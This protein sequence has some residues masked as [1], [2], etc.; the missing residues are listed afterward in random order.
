MT[1]EKQTIGRAK[2]VLVFGQGDRQKAVISAIVVRR[3][4]Q[5]NSDG[6]LRFAGNVKFSSSVSDHVKET[7]LPIVDN[8]INGL[9]LSP[10]NFEI[11]AVNLGVAS[12]LDVGMNISGFSSDVPMFIGM[13]SAGL[14]IPVP[15]D[16]VATGHIASV[17]G[18]IS[19]VRAI[20]AKVEAVKA[21]NTISCFM[22]P[23]IEKDTSLTALTPIERD[24]SIKAIMAAK[25]FVRTKPIE[26]IGELVR[27]VFTEEGIVLAS[28][29]Q[30][31]FGISKIL[32]K[33]N[34]PVQGCISFLTNR[35]EKRF[36]NV[37]QRYFLAG[38]CEKGKELL[39]AFAEFHIARQV[40]PIGLGTMLSGL[41]CSLPPTVRRL[42][43]C[44]PILDTGMCIKLSESARDLDF[45]DVSIL[46]DAAHGKHLKQKPDIVPISASDNTGL[47]DSACKTF[48]DVVA[49]INEKAFAQK[50]G[51]AIDSARGSFVLNSIRVDSYDEF[52]DT[53]V[54]F[55]VHLKRHINPSPVQSVDM[56]QSRNDATALA[57]RAFRNKGGCEAAYTQSIE[58]TRGGMRSV[59]DILTEQFKA[60]ERNEY[61]QRVFKDALNSLGWSDRV[62]FVRGAMKHLRPFLPEK[63]RNEPAERYAR[64]YETIIQAYV[65]SMD[66]VNQLL[67]SM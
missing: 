67:N 48:D 56:D 47:S 5:I 42:K 45:N 4:G 13:L 3:V 60:E 62:D 54:S 21:D 57:E 10:K 37:L 27:A 65:K 51:I 55:Y 20:P 8:I 32:D 18:D 24:R 40:Y 50:Y 6:R 2:T 59:L 36:W 43:T 44:F 25:D 26:G 22:H 63:I 41:I 23:D 66:E 49:M 17:E 61:V 30:G 1:I 35:N 7:I 28:L 11:S 16:L 12:S 34:N 53:I 9:S 14:Q 46:F 38:E 58:G 39:Q 29:R 52:A 64:N 15:N 19:A 31:F 33:F